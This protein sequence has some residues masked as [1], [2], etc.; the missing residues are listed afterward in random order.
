VKATMER[1]GRRGCASQRPP[2]PAAASWPG[3]PR[4]PRNRAGMFW[5]LRCGHIF[6]RGR[7]QILAR[8]RPR[9]QPL[10]PRAGSHHP[11]Q[12][13]AACQRRTTRRRAAQ[14]F[15]ACRHGRKGR[16]GRLAGARPRAAHAA[17]AGGRGL[18]RGGVRWPTAMSGVAR[19]YLIWSSCTWYLS[20]STPRDV[21][22]SINAPATKAATVNPW[23]P[24]RPR[25]MT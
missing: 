19:L 10:L 7:R 23:K 4:A 22:S 18:W 12:R 20:W 17:V 24:T 25:C 11:D 9:V 16:K 8:K 13:K 6:F 15:S 14:P 2:Y 21:L 3:S 5:L 1:H